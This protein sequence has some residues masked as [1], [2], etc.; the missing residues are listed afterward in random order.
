MIMK[1]EMV[2]S[3]LHLPLNLNAPY[4]FCAY[5]ARHTK[6]AL[7]I[8]S[9]VFQSSYLLLRPFQIALLPLLAPSQRSYL[10][11]SQTHRRVESIACDAT[12]SSFQSHVSLLSLTPQFCEQISRLIFLHWLC[13]DIY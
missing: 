3:T 12:N 10:L 4:V 13:G 6:P 8:V 2:Y 7:C 5:V 1:V 9:P 11:Q